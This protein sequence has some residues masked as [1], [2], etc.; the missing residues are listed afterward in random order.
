MTHPFIRNS[1]SG[2]EVTQTIFDQPPFWQIFF[3][4]SAAQELPSLRA[5]DVTIQEKLASAVCGLIL[6]ILAY[7]DWEFCSR[8]G[9]SFIVDAGLGRQ[10]QL[11]PVVVVFSRVLLS[12]TF[13]AAALG[14]IRAVRST[15]FVDAVRSTRPIRVLVH[16]PVTVAATLQCIALGLTC[17]TLLN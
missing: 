12:V 10:S 8:F 16:S 14:C 1:R 11:I 3:S 13:V 17:L 5:P 4:L 6:P 2:G 9:Q 15:G 7:F